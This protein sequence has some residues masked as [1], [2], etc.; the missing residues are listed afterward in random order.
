MRRVFSGVKVLYGEEFKL[1]KDCYILIDEDGKIAE[2]GQGSFEGSDV[3]NCRGLLAIPSFINAHSHIGDSFAKER[4]YGVEFTKIVKPPNGLKHKLLKKEKAR[5]VVEAIKTTLKD[6]LASGITIFADFRENG[7]KGV[8][9]LRE[10]LKKFK[11]YSIIFGRPSI[12]MNEETL[13]ENLKPLHWKILKEVSNLLEVADGIGLSSPNEYTD[14]ALMQISSIF[15]GKKLIATHAAEHP[16]SNKIS[17]ERS[18]YSE[19]YRALKILKADV[20]VHLTNASEDD[21]EMVKDEK[22]GVVVCPRANSIL[23]VGFPPVKKLMDMDVN[24]AL[25]SDNVMVNQPDMFREMDYILRFTN[26]LEKKPSTLKPEEVFK[27]STINAAKVLKIEDKFGSIEEGK[28]ANLVFINPN[29]LN[30][31]YTSKLL[32]TIILRGRNENIK[33][34]TYHGETVFQREKI[35]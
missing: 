35:S 6:M 19:V 25:G 32:T 27:M 16:E 24:V 13:K 5:T 12:Y 30:L 4:G 3:V 9:I 29:D 15:K 28:I 21:L 1:V 26:A 34:V 23:G 14:K 10:A 20:L 33:L 11:V 31:Q 22:V 18:G 2:I 7:V 8:E 17:F